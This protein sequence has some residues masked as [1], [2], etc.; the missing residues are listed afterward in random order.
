MERVSTRFLRLTRRNRLRHLY[1][2]QL[3]RIPEEGVS[4]DPD[5]IKI[6]EKII[7]K[8]LLTEEGLSL[9]QED[10]L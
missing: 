4:W 9:I 10:E 3:E 5:K 1:E 6:S 2:V 8:F 7:G